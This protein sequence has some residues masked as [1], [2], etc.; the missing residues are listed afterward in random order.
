M[1]A[2]NRRIGSVPRGGIVA[3]FPNDVDSATGAKA[4][5]ARLNQG[6]GIAR[7]PNPAG[8]LD[9]DFHR[10]AHQRHI[11]DRRNA[12][13]K[14]GRSLH[15]IRS[16]FFAEFTRNPLFV[17]GKK[18]RFDDHFQQSASLVRD[19]R[20]FFDFRFDE[21]VVFRFQRADVD[22]HVDFLCAELQRLPRLKTFRART[23]PQG[24]TNNRS[25]LHARAPQAPRRK[26]DVAGIHHHRAKL[27]F[28]LRRK[29]E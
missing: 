12:A 7:G 23:R 10:A 28:L 5:C 16:R 17:F 3:Q 14:S 27:K 8:R 29:V 9:S 22:D 4:I 15:E 20:Q 19:P 2:K 24:K 21:C 26:L 18:T 25:D 6:H 1:P 13:E 11:C